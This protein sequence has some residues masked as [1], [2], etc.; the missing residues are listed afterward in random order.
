MQDSPVISQVLQGRAQPGW[1]V[2]P[3]ISWRCLLQ[4]L[5]NLIFLLLGMV[6]MT[7]F[8]WAIYVSGSSIPIGVNAMFALLAIVFVYMTYYFLRRL[9]YSL[10]CFFAANNCLVITPTEFHLNLAGNCHVYVRSQLKSL[11][12]HSSNDLLLGSHYIAFTDANTGKSAI[13]IKDKY[14]GALDEVF[15]ILT[16]N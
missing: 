16:N 15:R 8:A 1:Y 6:F 3:F 5:I 4:L 7:G 12:L 10:R 13:L 2:F 9:V 14:F 11:V